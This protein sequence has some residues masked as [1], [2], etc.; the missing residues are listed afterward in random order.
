MPLQ[1]F[2]CLEAL[3][4][5]AL[6]NK[7][8]RL[9][10]DHA[11]ALRQLA[12]LGGSYTGAGLRHLMRLLHLESLHVASP[13]SFTD[14]QMIALVACNGA[15]AGASA[16]I[17]VEKPPMAIGVNNNVMDVTAVARA[18]GNSSDQ[19]GSGSCS[20][21]RLQQLRCLQLE[22]CRGLTD[23]S[24]SVIAAWLP[25]LADCR[26]VAC[27][28]ITA[29]GLSALVLNAPRLQRVSV[30]DRCGVGAS[31]TELCQQRARDVR[32]RVEITFVH[33]A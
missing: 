11:P 15:S 26:V 18:N 28:Q 1:T 20:S 7:H 31:G 21:G 33:T 23:L 12:C 8:L 27:R 29:A 3:S 2:P 14:D 9:L 32:K 30:D 19:G 25:Q 6:A 13:A 5:A 22:S 10:A 24:C 17:E 4:A 16:T